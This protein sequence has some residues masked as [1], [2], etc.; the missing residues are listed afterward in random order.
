MEQTVN[1]KPFK[2]LM[3]AL[4]ILSFVGGA[5]IS[6]AQDDGHGSDF[7]GELRVAVWGQID[8]ATDRPDVA[9]I[10][11][12][13]QQW[14]AMYP[15]VDLKYDYIGGT[16]VTERFTWINTNLMAGTLPD[17]VMIYFPGPDIINALDLL[18]N[19]EDDL[20]QPNPYSTNPTWWDDFPLDQ[21]ILN[22]TVSSDG[23]HRVIGPTLSGDSGVTAFAYN[24]TMF[25]E[26]GVEPPQTW[27]E[28][29]E[30]QQKLKDAGHT[31]FLMQMAGPLGWIWNW[32]EWTIREQLMADVIDECDIRAPFD[33][34]DDEEMAYCV[35]TGRLTLDDPRLAETWRLMKEWS[36]YWQDDFLAP[37]PDA[38][39]FAQGDVAMINTMNLWLGQIASNPNIKFEWGTFYQP[40]VTP[41]DSEYGNDVTPR[42]VG[43]KGFAGSGSIYFFIPMTTV[44]RSEKR[45]A[46]AIDLIQWFTAPP[47]LELWCSQQPIPCY[48]PGTPIEDVFDDPKMVTEMRGFFEP[49]AFENGVAGLDW[50]TL[51]R[52]LADEWDRLFAE[53]MG[54]YMSAEEAFD[55]FDSSL[56]RTVE[57]AIRA[58]PEWEADS[59]E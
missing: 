40:P 39:L 37:P 1:T 44:E 45:T 50:A 32:A 8:V 54:G 52:S 47:Q 57:R 38:D 5:Q 27:G 14:Q 6:I 31:P 17:M 22:Q 25:D 9:V 29:M 4:L 13:F 46:E 7:S 43:N 56:Q 26:V 15:D 19:F 49:G 36:Q 35:S 16:S 41:A 23:G 24:K 18:Y 42:R 34:I 51:D 28:F 58:H 55:E 30:I 10:D 11:E 48:E 3:I 33:S 20:H 12:I 59:W 21:L 53:Y 2:Y